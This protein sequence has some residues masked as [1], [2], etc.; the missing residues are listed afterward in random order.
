MNHHDD[1]GEALLEAFR[2]LRID[3]VFS[4]PG[5]E[6]SPVWEAMSRQTLEG[7][8]GPAFLDCWHENVA[9]D[10]A[11]GYAAYTGRMQAVLLH[12]GVG[13]M[14]GAMAIM[15]ADKIETPMLV[16]SGESVTFGD[17][18]AIAIEPQF[19]A[20]V[21]EGGA[22]RFIAPVVKYAT[23]VVSH[24][25]LYHT[26][27]RAGE[28]AQRVPQGPVYVNVAMEAL[29]HAW[30]RP[31]TLAPIPPAPRMQAL[32]AD[33][34]AVAD[35][36]RKAQNPVVVTETAGRDPAAFE[37]LVALCDALALPVMNARSSYFSNFPHDHPM[38]QGYNDLAPC[39]EADLILLVNV[40]TPFSPPSR[41]PGRGAI[42]CMGEYPHKHHLAYQALHADHY[43]EGDCAT[44]LRALLAAARPH[45]N[46]AQTIAAR[47]ARWSAAHDSLRA[48]LAAQRA[49]SL[50]APDIDAVALAAVAAKLL[51]ADAIVCDETI[52]HMPAMRPHLPLNAPRSFFR[53]TGGALGQGI[54]AALGAKL[55][56]PER[57][58]VLFIGDGSFLYNPIVQALGASKAH[59]LPI[60]IVVCDNRRYEAMRKGH[61][62]YYAGGAAET[63]RHHHGVEIEGPEYHELGRSFGMAG[64]K[65]ERL[66]DLE[67]AFARALAQAKGG[68]TAILNVQLVK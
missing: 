65:A 61:V 25:T 28:M 41:R 46:E 39:E 13:L 7:R 56:A 9:V 26:V 37:A 50:A 66:A 57:P 36:L 18:P 20:G 52:T 15:S 54:A 63:S 2:N 8:P 68:R 45:A 60:V 14:H 19:Y 23:Q 17:D 24:A 58:V 11:L 47:R 43:L 42:V 59:K 64:E 35:L 67:P 31:A 49:Q 27:A 5:S 29:L 12:A 10:M 4:S 22:Q 3:Y 51:P 48:R 34:A 38:W 30:S 44:A 40:R 62:L 55:A 16:M 1:G 33:I 32:D 6:W 53:V 21:S